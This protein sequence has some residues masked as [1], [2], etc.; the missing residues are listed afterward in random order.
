MARTSANTMSRADRT[1]I[2]LFALMVAAIPLYLVSNWVLARLEAF[3]LTARAQLFGQVLVAILLEAFPFVLV[4][5]IVSGLVEVLVPPER[6]ARLIPRRLWLRLLLAA[7]AGVVFP[8]C[9]CG[10]VPVARRLMRKGL[11]VE[12]AL[13]FMLAGPIVNPTVIASTAVAFMGQ[14]L[15]LAMTVARVACGV[16]VALAVG[17]VAWRWFGKSAAAE[18]APATG[19]ASTGGTA[20]L[21]NILTHVV[22]DFL[23]LGGYLLLGSFIAAALQAFVPRD[24]LVSVGSKPVLASAAMMLMAFLLNLCSEADAFVAAA[25]AQF[26]FAGRLAFLVFGPMLDVKLVA[27]YLGAFPKRMLVAVLLLVPPL[28]LVACELAGWL[29]GVLAG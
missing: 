24:L 11:P 25:M 15:S 8:V 20:V 16:A 18:T 5:S 9:E 12:M 27:M 4:G 19:A 7:G 23:L 29:H 2:A 6:L 26:S 13:V 3:F 10:I 14:G 21:P 17:L 22:H 28:C 1:K